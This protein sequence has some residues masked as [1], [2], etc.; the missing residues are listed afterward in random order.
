MGS[1]NAKIQKPEEETK[2]N[3]PSESDAIIKRKTSTLYRCL[4]SLCLWLILLFPS[5]LPSQFNRYPLKARRLTL[6]VS[7]HTLVSAYRDA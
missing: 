7:L 2:T 5:P 1:E 6:F 3:V 4:K